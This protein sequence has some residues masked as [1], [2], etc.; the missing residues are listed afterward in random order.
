MWQGVRISYT[1][2]WRTEEFYGQRGG[3]QQFGSVNMSVRF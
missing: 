1:Q 2:V 3:M